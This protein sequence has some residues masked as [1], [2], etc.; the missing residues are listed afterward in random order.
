[1]KKIL[2][3]L[4]L[5]LTTFGAQASSDQ[6]VF[7]FSFSGY[8][9]GR[10]T[11]VSCDYAEYLARDWMDTFGATNLDVSCSGGITPTGVWPISLRV[12]YTAPVLSETPVTEEK[13]IRSGPF[14][15]SNCS[16]DTSLM[17]DLLHA[18][19]NVTVTRKRDACF[20]PDSSYE[21]KINVLL[22]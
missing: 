16:F 4:L 5:S 10:Y 12:R 14:G 11:M 19:S 8:G 17:R 9:S 22:N 2:F 18:F 3:A 7:H 20:A 13:V 15:Q 6:S 21:Y 1:M